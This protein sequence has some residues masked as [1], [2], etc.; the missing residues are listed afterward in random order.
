VPDVSG[1]M[2]CSSLSESAV[3]E[4]RCPSPGEVRADHNKP[5]NGADEVLNNNI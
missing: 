4:E 5:V 3:G 1:S 2:G